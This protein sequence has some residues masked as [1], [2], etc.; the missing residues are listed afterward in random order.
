MSRRSAFSIPSTNEI[1]RHYK[2][3]RFI[4]GEHD[5]DLWLT[6]S[7]TLVRLRKPILG[8]VKSLLRDYNLDLE[9]LVANVGSTI[10]KS[11]GSNPPA[12]GSLL[13][14]R[15]TLPLK[16]HDI[17]GLPVYVKVERDNDLCEVWTT[18]SGFVVTNPRHTDW[19][20][21]IHP[22]GEWFADKSNPAIGPITHLDSEGVVT[23]LAMP[24]RTVLSELVTEAAA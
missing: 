13:G 9:P 8:Q 7:Y 5:D 20:R 19:I 21:R 23:A 24:I 10:R 12:I 3:G 14:T 16:Q 1:L 4:I 2:G 18:G 15:D 17:G 6:D 22:G 11:D